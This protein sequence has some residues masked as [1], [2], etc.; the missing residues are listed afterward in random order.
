MSVCTLNDPE[1]LQCCCNCKHLYP[2]YEHCSTN[3]DLRKWFEGRNVR[4]HC[5][6]G[7]RNGWA[8]TLEM[9]DGGRIFTNWSEHSV[10]CEC[11]DPK[12]SDDKSGG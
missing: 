3:P 2:T 10:G 11:Y 9:H 8:C 7:I 12:K 4:P 1:V 6:C 5:I